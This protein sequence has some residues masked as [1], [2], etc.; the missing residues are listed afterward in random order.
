MAEIMMCLPGRGMEAAGYNGTGS[1]CKMACVTEM[2]ELRPNIRAPFKGLVLRSGG[3]QCLTVSHLQDTGNHQQT[4][5]HF[6][7]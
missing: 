6:T 3:K 4:K 7:L 2:D 1:G 5:R